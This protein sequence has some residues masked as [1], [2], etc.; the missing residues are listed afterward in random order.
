MEN[1]GYTKE[2]LENRLAE[3]QKNGTHIEKCLDFAINKIGEYKKAINGLIVDDAI[4]EVYTKL[5]SALESYEKL[6]SRV[7][8][9]INA[10]LEEIEPEEK[11]KSSRVPRRF[12]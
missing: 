3:V 4:F 7:I 10:K 12:V 1:F 6:N 9:K 2:D 8:K 11:E 5:N